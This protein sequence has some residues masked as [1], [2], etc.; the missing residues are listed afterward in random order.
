M[1]VGPLDCGVHLLLVLRQHYVVQLAGW[2]EALDYVLHLVSVDPAMEIE[3]KCPH[4]SVGEEQGLHP[5]LC[6]V[7]LDCNVVG[8]IAVMD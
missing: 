7:V 8:E 3:C 2:G 1:D 4:F 5:P 6:E